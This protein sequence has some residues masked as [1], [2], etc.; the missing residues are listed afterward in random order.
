MAIVKQVMKVMVQIANK[1]MVYNKTMPKLNGLSIKQKQFV[2]GKIA[3]KTNA[4][5][6]LDAGYS[7]HNLNTA[8]ANSSKLLNQHN[9]RQAIERAL[10]HHGATPEYAVGVLKQVADQDKEIGARRLAAKDILELHGW[11]RGDRPTVSVEI[12]NAF[13]NDTRQTKVI[14]QA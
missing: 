7:A 13:F 12:G 10:E 6:Y 3:G 9:I 5:A 14:D 8:N 2:A 1:R 11:Q 4:K